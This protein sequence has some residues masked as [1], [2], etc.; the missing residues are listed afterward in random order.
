[1]KKIAVWGTGQKCRE[2][3]DNGKAL[4]IDIFIDND[5][6]KKDTCFEG[7]QVFYPS[8]IT[9]WKEIY[10]IV[11]VG[12]YREIKK[13]LIDIGLEEYRDFCFYEDFLWMFL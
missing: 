13:Q 6:S 10:V 11:A 12:A 4:N 3:L 1:M 2:L 5:I 7:K 9:G 8:S